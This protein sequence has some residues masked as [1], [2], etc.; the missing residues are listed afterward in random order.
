MTFQFIEDIESTIKDLT[1]CI[2]DGGLICF[3][4]FNCDFGLNPKKG[5][6]ENLSI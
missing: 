4:V 6:A 3:S 1:N 2:N 5:V